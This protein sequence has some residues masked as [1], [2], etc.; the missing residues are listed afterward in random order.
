MKVSIL[1]LHCLNAIAD[2]YETAASILDDVR[3][4]S[5]GRIDAADVASCLAELVLDG[6]AEAYIFDASTAEY[7]PVAAQPRD[8]GAVWFRITAAG[9]HQLDENW[10]E[11]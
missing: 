7:V 2:D 1:D 6:M 4:S 3:R 5:H 8:L 10:I 9:R 11:E